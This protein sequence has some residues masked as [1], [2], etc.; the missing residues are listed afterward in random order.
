M[1]AFETI[2]K[3][4]I[5]CCR[6]DNPERSQNFQHCSY[7]MQMNT[8]RK[9]QKRSSKDHFEKISHRVHY[10]ANLFLRCFWYSF[11]GRMVAHFVHRR[12]PSLLHILRSLEG[13]KT[14]SQNPLPCKKDDLNCREGNKVFSGIRESFENRDNPITFVL[15]AH[16][17]CKN[18]KTFIRQNMSRTSKKTLGF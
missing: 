5:K 6:N 17:Q 10:F 2:Y 3:N 7:V 16:Y 12:P 13:D 8:S 9:T 1:E 14:L 18:S 15:K 11:W 4:V